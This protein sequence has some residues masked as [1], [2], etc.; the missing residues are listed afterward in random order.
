MKPILSTPNDC[1]YG[2]SNSCILYLQAND[3]FVLPIFN[4][5][6]NLLLL[7]VVIVC[8]SFLCYM[9]SV[10]SYPFLYLICFWWLK[11]DVF[12]MLAH[13]T[14]DIAPGCLLSNPS[15]TLQWQSRK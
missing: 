8:M 12:F 10:I 11:C 4:A 13:N 15:V 7:V 14:N 6:I 2:I 9:L 1:R 3:S 5:F